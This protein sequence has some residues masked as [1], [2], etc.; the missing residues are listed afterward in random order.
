MKAIFSEEYYKMNWERFL[1]K[2]PGNDYFNAEGKLEN[3]MKVYESINLDSD[4]LDCIRKIE[5]KKI[6]VEL[7]ALVHRE[8]QVVKDVEAGKASFG[9]ITASQEYKAKADFRKRFEFNC[10][11]LKYFCEKYGVERKSL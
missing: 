7:N 10:L 5:A 3:R 4:K 8:L 2:V 6:A 11:Q 9:M 1:V